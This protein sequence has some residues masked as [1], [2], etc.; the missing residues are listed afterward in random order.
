MTI[1]LLLAAFT[2]PLCASPLFAQERPDM[3]APIATFMAAA[4]ADWTTTGIALSRPGV[5]ESNPLLGFT[6]S[7]PTTTV[8][9]LII[10]DVAGA[11]AITR[12]VAP[13]KPRLAR[14]MLYSFAAARASM[15]I[16]NARVL[17]AQR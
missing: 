10:G 17:S 13:R 9:A 3:R 8:S 11:W 5:H 6:G 2:L 1:R 15:A 12:Y 16:H 7:R 4:A 14:V